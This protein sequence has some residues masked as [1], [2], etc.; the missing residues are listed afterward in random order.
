MEF[1]GANDIRT[2][3]SYALVTAAYNEADYIGDTIGSVISQEVRP[4][5]WVIVSDG[6]TDQTDAI[7]EKHAAKHS[8]I[9]L[10]RLTD[11][12]PRSFEAQ[13]HAINAGIAQLRACPYGFIGNLDAD[14]TFEPEYF[15]LLLNKFRD[16]PQLGLGGGMI[17]ERCS[18]GEFKSRRNNKVTSVAH[19]V[20]LFRRD[21]FESVGARYQ[22]LPYGA[23]DTYA[24]VTARMK[25]WQVSSFPD[26]RVFHHR[27]TSSA[28]GRLRGCFR[29][30]RMDYSL[31]IL[32][33]YEVAKI[34]NRMGD[35]P[36]IFG[37][38]TRFG[39]F[40]YSYFQNEQRPVSRE[41]IAYFRREQA[42]RLIGCLPI[43]KS[44]DAPEKIGHETVSG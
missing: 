29:Q 36:Y 43:S 24:E 35:K 12:H 2:G 19:A 39:G 20:Q 33:I 4:V 34:L 10:Y 25:G 31:G 8:F 28:G 38:I 17:H 6:S 14:V 5:K 9:Q 30:G 1:G 3:D 42:S 16:T 18:D 37:A 27:P 22:A 44:S 21:C 13:A 23:P 11:P 41:F 40:A 26:L 7:V 15:R 32:P